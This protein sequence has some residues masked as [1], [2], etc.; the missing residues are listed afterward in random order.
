MIAGADLSRWLA[1]GDAQQRTQA[2]MDGFARE[3]RLRPLMAELERDVMALDPR[4]TDGLLDIARRFIGRTAEL[5]GVMRDIIS[6]CRSDP[7]FSPPFYP[8]INELFTGFLLCHHPDIS[9]AIGVTSLDSLAVKK[10][11]RRGAGSI[12]FTGYTTLMRFID[13]G[14]ATL[15]L[16]KAPPIGQN[17]SGTGSGECRL[18]G[19][20]RILDGDEILVDGREES[21]VIEHASR[22]MVY[23]QAMVRAEA[24]PLSAEYDSETRRF[25]GASS[26]DEASSRVQMMATLLREMDREDALP[27][28]EESLQSPLFYARWHIMREMLA[29]DA[30]AALPALRRMAAE[31]P[32][33][34]VREAAGQTLQLFFPDEAAAPAEQGAEQCRA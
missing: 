24:A 7:F 17:F 29:L 8:V 9:I 10:S 27:V 13:A 30:E 16:W 18:V 14:E 15:S 23:F 1:D 26:T 32:H 28:L 21:F 4:T 25:V 33:L 5:E 3:L 20:R 11:S 6:A 19:R 12:N 22:D 34:E 31:D 2:R